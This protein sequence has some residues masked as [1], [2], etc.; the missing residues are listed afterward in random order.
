MNTG[1]IWAILTILKKT[2]QRS[3]TP[4]VVAEWRSDKGTRFLVRTRL[5]TINDSI[6]H[7]WEHYETKEVSPDVVEA[8]NVLEA[9][10]EFQETR[11]DEWEKHNDFVQNN[12][13]Q[14]KSA[15]EQEKG[16]IEESL[17]REDG[18]AWCFPSIRCLFSI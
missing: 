9:W 1:L 11:P 12:W 13:E 6:S 10:R 16:K 3:S 5:E 18:S 14:E 17:E 15:N 7:K 4:K 8:M 2:G